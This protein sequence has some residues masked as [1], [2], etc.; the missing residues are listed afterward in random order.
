MIN[1]STYA[2]AGPNISPAANT[3]PTDIPS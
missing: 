2:I 3:T 1:D